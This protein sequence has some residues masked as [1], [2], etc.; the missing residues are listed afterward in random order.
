MTGVHSRVL[1]FPL[2]STADP[3]ADKLHQVATDFG[4]TDFQLHQWLC[5]HAIPLGD[6]PNLFRLKT[7][8]EELQELRRERDLLKR[9]QDFLRK[10]IANVLSQQH[11]DVYHHAIITGRDNETEGGRS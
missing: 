5:R 9:E 3:H 1:L 2:R 8:T 10:F 7:S 11:I 6:V 4:I